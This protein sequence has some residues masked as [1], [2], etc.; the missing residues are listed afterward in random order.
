[1]HE[2]EDIRLYRAISP[3]SRPIADSTHTISEIGFFVA[4]I[5]LTS[6]ITGQGYLLSFHY[7]PE[8]I[9]GALRDIVSM[10]KGVPVYETGRLIQNVSAENE[11]FGQD[12]LQK[13]A[14]AVV[15]VA[16]WDC[17]G[18]FLGM[19][20][21]KILGTCIDRIPVYGSGGWLSYTIEELIDEV[22]A[23]KKRGFT[24]VKVKVGSP[25]IEQDLERL[26]KVREAVGPDLKIMM[27]ANQGMSL[28]DAL[29]L[30]R[31]AEDLNIFCFEEPIHHKNYEGYAELRRK[32]P[33]S[34]A[35]GEREYDIEPL[36]ALIHR[37]AID[38]WQPDLIRIGGVENWL[39]S[40]ALANAYHIPVLPH[41]YKDYDVPLLCTIPNGLGAE[42]FDWIDGIIDNKMRIENGY[43]YPREASGWGFKFEEK[44]LTEI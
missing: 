32:N 44:Y 8:A 3:L 13:W 6:G 30:S 31:K 4:E 7:S 21:W 15:N 34:L 25:N 17:W 28:Q 14:L 36:K 22:T 27:D 33:L 40:A 29:I 16:M 23:Y 18:K 10:A 41:Y 12:G 11:Y 42:S 1:M 24:S 2:I 39:Q 38:L 43:A 26:R 37:Q 9:S 5:E 19:P 35:M 20:I